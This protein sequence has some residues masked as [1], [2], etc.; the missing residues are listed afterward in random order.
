MLYQEWL[1]TSTPIHNV[2]ITKEQI[3]QFLQGIPESFRS[4]ASRIPFTYPIVL[5]QNTSVPWLENHDKIVIHGQQTFKY[6]R[7]IKCNEELFYQ[8]HLANVREVKG[9]KGVMYLLDCVMN[10]KDTLE[11]PVLLSNTTLLLLD[12]PDNPLHF[13]RSEREKP[14]LLPRIHHIW[15]KKST[16][17]PGTT[18]FDAQIGT[19]TGDML[20]AYAIASNDNNAIHLDE[21]KAN[22]VGVPHRIAQ[23]MLI[24]GMIGNVLQVLQTDDLMLGSLQCRFHVPIMEGDT[25]R[26]VVLIQSKLLTVERPNM[27]CTLE[28]FI[29][30]SANSKQS[31]LAYSG[32]VVYYLI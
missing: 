18:L 13:P 30:N 23:G 9:S 11:Q 31:S 22:E 14:L 27:D 29:E 25:V 21:Q 32:S 10:V 17:S 7:E 6:E 28:V 26:V 16:L 4:D 1:G 15:N 24:L 2:I 8:I 12:K 3:T 5:W 20:Y 19:I